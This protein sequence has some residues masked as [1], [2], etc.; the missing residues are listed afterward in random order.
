[1]GTYLSPPHTQILLFAALG[2]K[3]ST[4]K[5]EALLGKNRLP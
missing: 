3:I 2:K 5:I 1:M 4:L